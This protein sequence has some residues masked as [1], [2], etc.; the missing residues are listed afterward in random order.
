MNRIAAEVPAYQGVT[1]TRLAETVEQ[2]PIV[3]REDMYYGG[4]SYENS[5]GL[6]VQLGPDVQ[7]GAA[8]ALSWPQPQ[9]LSVPVDKMLA[10]PTNRL[11]DCGRTLV[12]SQLLHRRL[13]A[14][15]FVTLNPSDAR[16]LKTRPGDAVEISFGGNSF[17]AEARVDDGVPRGVVLAPRSLGMP[18][19]GPTLVS[20]RV[21]ERAAA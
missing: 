3:H 4:T 15:R 6:G 11:Y 5:Q 13:P 1:Y 7:R 8:V 17:V 18:V 21:V 14:Q 2:W 16:G 9:H 12:P 10:V 19:N 20:M